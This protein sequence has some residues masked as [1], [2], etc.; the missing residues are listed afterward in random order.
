M[1]TR[2][3]LDGVQQVSTC[4]ILD[5]T[6]VRRQPVI[7]DD[8]A[9]ISRSSRCSAYPPGGRGLPRPVA[10]ATGAQEAARSSLGWGQRPWPTS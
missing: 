9:S 2:V 5:R 10:E 7:L 1:Q 3:N 4:D 8:E 6:L